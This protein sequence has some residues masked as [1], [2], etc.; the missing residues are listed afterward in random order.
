MLT[1][2]IMSCHL[3]LITKLHPLEDNVPDLLYIF[4]VHLQ[5]SS[6]SQIHIHIKEFIISIN[7]GK[8]SM[9]QYFAK[10]SIKQYCEQQL[11]PNLSDHFI[12]FKLHDLVYTV[13]VLY[14]TFFLQNVHPSQTQCHQTILLPVLWQ[15]TMR[16]AI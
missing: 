15:M 14:F 12:M 9:Y 4:C 7:K 8:E 16:K 5:P 1:Y 10:I 13:I 3:S 11:Q 6:Q 2:Y